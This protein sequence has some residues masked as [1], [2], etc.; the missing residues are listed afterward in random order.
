MLLNRAIIFSALSGI[1]IAIALYFIPVG[2]NDTSFFKQLIYVI[3]V[4]AAYEVTAGGPLMI[5]ILMTLESASL[6][7]PSEVVLPLSGFLIA[8]GKMGLLPVLFA[9]IAGSLIGSLADYY[10]GYLIGIEAIYK[11]SWISAKSLMAATSWFNRYGVWAVVFSRMLAGARTLISF[12]AGV[13]KMEIKRFLFFT[14]LGSALWSWL[15]IYIGMSVGSHWPTI[16]NIIDKIVVPAGIGFIV[17]LL[18]YFIYWLLKVRS[19]KAP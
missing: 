19:V 14:L 13:F 3:P 5:F 12:P 16:V 18:F 1:I 6:P 7:I 2:I 8:Q 11:K 10:I 4:W 9:S 17:A 15:L